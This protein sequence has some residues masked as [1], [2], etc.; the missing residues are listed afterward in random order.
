MVCTG[1]GL[2]VAGA[3][4]WAT[5]QRD[6]FFSTWRPDRS[7]VFGPERLPELARPVDIP[8]MRLLDLPRGF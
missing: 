5:L 8:P 7:H 1:P 3:Y 2:V 6:I 4:L